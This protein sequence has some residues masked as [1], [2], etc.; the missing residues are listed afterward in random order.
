MLSDFPV[1][2][3]K[4]TR[5]GFG[6]GIYEIAKQNP[7]VV[8]LTADL[9]GSLKL[10]AFIIDFPERFIQCGIAEANMMGIAAGMTIGGKIPYTT[11]FAN[12]STS[13]VY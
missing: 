12:F 7:H 9:A 13:R 11:T 4:E 10:N 6:E 1:Q 5:A 2:N 3:E 8:A